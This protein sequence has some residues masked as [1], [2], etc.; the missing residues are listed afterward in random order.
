MLSKKETLLSVDTETTGL[1]P[2]RS[3]LRLIQIAGRDT[4]ETFLIDYFKITNTKPLQEFMLNFI[5]KLNYSGQ[6]DSYFFMHNFNAYIEHPLDLFLGALLLKHYGLPP[7]IEPD[8]KQARHSKLV[9]YIKDKLIER[10]RGHGTLKLNSVLKLFTGIEISKELQV[11]DWSGNLT[12]AQ[13]NYAAKDVECLY[14]LYDSMIEDIFKEGLEQTFVVENGIQMVTAGLHYDG[15]KVDRKYHKALGIEIETKLSD[16]ERK[17]SE[18]PEFQLST[19]SMLDMLEGKTSHI[20]FG[21]PQQKA[22]ALEK[23]WGRDCWANV[24]LEK[25]S[26]QAADLKKFIDKDPELVMLLSRHS[27]LQS[28]Y[29]NHI[30]GLKPYINPET[31]RVHS[32]YNQNSS[33]QQ[34]M[35]SEKPIL[36]NIP[37]KVS[38]GPGA[39]DPTS[40]MYSKNNF[41]DMFVPEEGCVF[42]KCDYSALQ[43]MAL[44]QESQD[45]RLLKIFNEGL[46]AH[47][48]TASAIYEKP[49]AEISNDSSLRYTAK[50]VNYAVGFVCGPG[51]LQNTFSQDDHYVSYEDCEMFIDKFL[52]TYPGVAQYHKTQPERVR[53]ERR[54]VVPGGRTT[55]LKDVGKR[56]TDSVNFCMNLYEQSGEKLALSRIGRV[57]WKLRERGIIARIVLAVH[58]EIMIEID[59]CYAIEISKILQHEMIRCMSKYIYAVPVKADAIICS[60][61]GGKPAEIKESLPL[62]FEYKFF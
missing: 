29:S 12:D 62:P 10:K 60:T 56:L 31:G 5:P 49:E 46:D 53:R 19:Q 58:D 3:K 44:A 25:P 41:R 32:D 20:D 36:L 39:K 47:T 14:P 11:S 7:G 48:I 22:L 38:Y 26:T 9:A 59:S 54:V 16:L 40:P 42:I 37:T 35:S 2:R 23:R 33:P 28:M 55:L 18:Y 21:S 27:S 1:D 43:L 15:I 24:G 13:L 17:I 34:R 50:T 57:L 52:K 30:E 61:W 45:P 6:F 8:T 51:T 4:K